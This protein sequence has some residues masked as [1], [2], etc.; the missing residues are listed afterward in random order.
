MT[1]DVVLITNNA[2]IVGHLSS[3]RFIEG[4]AA[5]CFYRCEGSRPP[6]VAPFSHILFTANFR[7]SQQPFRSVLLRKPAISPAPVDM[8]S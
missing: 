5:G 2:R 8:D 4:V 1:V 6:G 3:S 7:P